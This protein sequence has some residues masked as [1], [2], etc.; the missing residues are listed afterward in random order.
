MFCFRFCVNHLTQVT[1]TGAFWQVDGAM[2][3]EFISKASRCGAFKNWVVLFLQFTNYTLTKWMWLCF[4]YSS[5]VCRCSKC[6]WLWSHSSREWRP[7]FFFFFQA[8]FTYWLRH[9]LAHEQHHS[10]DVGLE[11]KLHYLW[12]WNQH[13]GQFLWSHSTKWWHLYLSH[14][15]L[16]F[17]WCMYTWIFVCSLGQRWHVLPFT[18]GKVNMQKPGRD[19]KLLQRSLSD[20]T[21]R[22]VLLKGVR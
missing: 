1:Q 3:K 20:G 14:C 21:E 19:I 9:M 10:Q 18:F 5:G 7:F 17:T 12:I 22:D 16:F 2:L 15:I 4:E 13:F 6:Y 11:L 8:W